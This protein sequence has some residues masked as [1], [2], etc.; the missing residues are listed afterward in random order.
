LWFEINQNDTQDAIYS[1]ISG[2]G[3]SVGIEIKSLNYLCSGPQSQLINFLNSINSF[4]DQIKCLLRYQTT[5]DYL[6][7]AQFEAFTNS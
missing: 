3:Q 4:L 2:S 6:F 1:N 5:S 7:L